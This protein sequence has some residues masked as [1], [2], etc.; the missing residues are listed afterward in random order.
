MSSLARN[1]A[2]GGKLV[3]KGKVPGRAGIDQHDG[4]GHISKGRPH[5]NETGAKLVRGGKSYGTPTPRKPH[6]GLGANPVERA[7]S[8]PDMG[9]PQIKGSGGKGGRV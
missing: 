4:L 3:R 5:R 9:I 1:D 8:H 2:T 6:V 7:F